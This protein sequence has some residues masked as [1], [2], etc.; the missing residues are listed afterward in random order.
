M[1]DHSR[2]KF[3]RKKLYT[4]ETNVNIGAKWLFFFFLND[5]SRMQKLVFAWTMGKYA[6][7]Q[8]ELIR[9]NCGK[10]SLYLWR[11]KT[12]YNTGRG[13][14]CW[15]DRDQAVAFVTIRLKLCAQMAS[16]APL[17]QHFCWA[18]IIFQGFF[19]NY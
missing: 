9:S 1:N 11:I 15:Y 6:S 5:R 3:K 12:V 14:N 8:L 17:S 18:G 19:M 10:S 13:E 4:T 2:G 16:F 7:L